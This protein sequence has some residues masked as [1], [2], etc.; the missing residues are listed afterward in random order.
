MTKLV[1]L[2]PNLTI[3][4]NLNLNG[5]IDK[6]D[7]RS[8]HDRRHAIFDNAGAFQGRM[9]AKEATDFLAELRLACLQEQ[10]DAGQW[11]SHDAVS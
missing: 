4:Q 7:E 6:R 10:A 11:E 2:K 5:Y 9:N 1:T 8:D 3:R